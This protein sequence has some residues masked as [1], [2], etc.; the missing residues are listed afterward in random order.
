METTAEGLAT[1]VP[2][3]LTMDILRDGLSEFLLVDDEQIRETLRQ[4]IVESRVLM[5]GACATPIAGALA[6]PALVRD[7]TVVLPV[8]GRNLAL[9]KLRGLVAESQ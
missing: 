8:T 5:E 7:K 4:M 1:S 3:S 6:N 9:S 2:F